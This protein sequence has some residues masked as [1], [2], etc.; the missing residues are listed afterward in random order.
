[1]ALLDTPALAELVQDVLLLVHNINSSL[2][3]DVVETDD[4]ILHALSLEHP[5][6]A[7]LS[8]V[9]AVSSTAG[10]SVNSVNIDHS[11]LISRHDTSLIQREPVLPLSLGFVHHSF[12]DSGTL[13]DDPVGFVLDVLLLLLRE[14]PVVGDVEMGAF[15]GLLGSVLP[16][17]GSEHLPASGE[18]DVGSSVV[19]PQG[20]SPGLVNLYCDLLTSNIKLNLLVH[21]MHDYLSDLDSVDDLKLL[22]MAFNL[23]DSSVVL[24]PSTGRVD[25]ALV[26]N[27]QDLVSLVLLLHI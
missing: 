10:L 24:L 2:L 5:D 7:D 16:D 20:V 27:Q 14:G 15:R 9:I 17:M 19:G 4:S 26:E 18:H 12:V 21:H 22:L 23:D 13:G 6:P 25:G 3:A 8:S 1:V 11:E